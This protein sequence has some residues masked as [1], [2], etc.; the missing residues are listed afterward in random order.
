MDTEPK[1][2]WFT[3]IYS[4]ENLKCMKFLQSNNKTAVFPGIIQG[5]SSEQ[6]AKDFTVNWNTE[7]KKKRWEFRYRDERKKKMSYWSLDEKKEKEDKFKDMNMVMFKVKARSYSGVVNR[8]F[9]HRLNA[10][11]DEYQEVDGV[12]MFT[13]TEQDTMS[14]ADW[15]LKYPELVAK[16]KKELEEDARWR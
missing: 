13:L 6:D 12:H 10:R 8:E 11:V 9:I 14:L 5:W 4:D 7:D 16:E 1:D 15:K 3:A 2:I